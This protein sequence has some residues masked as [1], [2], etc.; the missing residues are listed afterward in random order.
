MSEWVLARLLPAPQEHFQALLHE[1]ARS[2]DPGSAFAELLEFLARLAPREYALAVGEAP[3][4]ALDTYWANYVAAT[5]EH[6]ASQKQV[7][8]PTWTRDVR[9]LDEPV[10]ASSLTSL[11][12]HLLVKSPPAFSRRN[13][14]VDA[15]LGDRV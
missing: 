4:A 2:K 1:L 12:L 13:L 15:T 5:V 3:R 14:F 7:R 8:A 9:P 10:F 11:R 6:G